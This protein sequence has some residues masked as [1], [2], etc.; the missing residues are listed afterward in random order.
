[1]ESKTVDDLIKR[2][3]ESMTPALP[4]KIL[5]YCD[6]LIEYTQEQVR[7]KVLSEDTIVKLLRLSTDLYIHHK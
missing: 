7:H 2:A 6:E 5:E 3:E 4:P 1:M